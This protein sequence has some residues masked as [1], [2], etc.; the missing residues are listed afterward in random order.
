MGY[1]TNEY[2]FDLS[3]NHSNF[4]VRLNR[5][6]AANLLRDAQFQSLLFR[7]EES[8]I[9]FDLSN[10]SFADID[11]LVLL[12]FFGEHLHVSQKHELYL[13]YPKSEEVIKDLNHCGFY[14]FA[15]EY[16]GIQGSILP[17]NN[18]YKR[19]SLKFISKVD[20]KNAGRLAVSLLDFIT[21]HLFPD[22]GFPK[23]NEMKYEYALPL[24]RA[25]H[26]LLKNIAN[27]SSSS[28]YMAFQKVGNFKFRIVIGDLGV[29]IQHS[30]QRKME[31]SRSDYLN[32]AILF[33]CND[34]II[35]GI[36]HVLKTVGAWGGDFVIRS[37]YF[38]KEIQLSPSPDRTNEEIKQK[39]ESENS[40]RV[41]FFLGTQ[42]VID[43]TVPKKL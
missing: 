31:L 23:N 21:E 39:V 9:F 35:D 5:Y 25:V 40:Q 37:G 17:D 15:Q 7:S 2:H 32:E 4:P 27:H 43:F 33:R 41:P 38:Q 12:L 3:Q 19:K 6:S 28:G 10:V 11:G 34:P 1:S 8:K 42:Y 20:S 24:A 13:T 36:F 16:F 30:M 18:Q 29:G 26:E 14:T 22:F